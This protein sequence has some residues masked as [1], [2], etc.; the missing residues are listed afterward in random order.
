[1]VGW[2]YGGRYLLREPGYTQ[3]KLLIMRCGERLQSKDD[4]N[5]FIIFRAKLR[6]EMAFMS[7]T[8]EIHEG[9][10]LLYDEYRA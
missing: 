3:I 9:Q 8:Q 7:V 6:A 10:G 5:A 4:R 2:H 1:M